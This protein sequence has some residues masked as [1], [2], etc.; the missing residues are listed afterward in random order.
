MLKLSSISDLKGPSAGHTQF[1][2]MVRFFNLLVLIDYIVFDS[3]PP[4][5][6]YKNRVTPQIITKIIIII[7]M[8]I[9]IIIFSYNQ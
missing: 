6:P 9:I 7:I 2:E 1:I 4:E 5:P 3:R 8:I